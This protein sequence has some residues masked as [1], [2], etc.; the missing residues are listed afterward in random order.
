MPERPARPPPSPC[1]RAS[2]TMTATVG[3]TSFA[4]WAA[5]STRS[6]PDPSDAAGYPRVRATDDPLIRDMRELGRV[7]G[8][9]HAALASD[10]VDP[11]FAP[12]PVTAADARRW[13]SGIAAAL[14]RASANAAIDRGDPELARALRDA[15]AGGDG[16]RAI[17]AGLDLLVGRGRA[18]DPLPWRLPPRAGPQDPRQLR[19]HR[20]RGR[21]GPPHRGAPSQAVPAPRRGRDAPLIELRG[22]SRRARARAP[23]SAHRPRSGSRTGSAWPATPSSTAT[24]APPAEAPCASSRRRATSSCARARPS[25][26]TRPATSSPTSSTIAPTGSRSPSPA[27]PASS[28]RRDSRPVSR[29]LPPSTAG[30]TYRKYASP[31]PAGAASQLDAAHRASRFSDRLQTSG[32][33]RRADVLGADA[34]AD[35]PGGDAAQHG[36]AREEPQGQ[37]R[38]RRQTAAQ[39]RGDDAALGH[40]LDPLGDAGGQETPPLDAREVLRRDAAGAERLREQVGGGHGVLHGQVDADAADRRHGVGGVADAQEA[41]A[42]PPLQAIDG[43]GQEADVV[44]ASKLADAVANEGRDAGEPLAKCLDAAPAELLRL[45]FG[46]TWPHCQ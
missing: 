7:T 23:A 40:H 11:A 4:R 21:A 33:A 9:L 14:D 5:P 36:E 44:P 37:R 13:E 31:A 6:P 46:M 28:S 20:L 18:Q 8:E 19:R 42:V 2:S 26:S 10:P 22:Q 27:C 30:S 35:E 29:S 43:D 24:R 16:T 38:A 12:E 41:R 45:P 1:C 25:R 15:T 32:A 3:A 34:H 39:H 17:R